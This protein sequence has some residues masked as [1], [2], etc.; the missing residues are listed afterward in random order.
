MK[1]IESMS[2]RSVHGTLLREMAA[3]QDIRLYLKELTEQAVPAAA[4]DDPLPALAGEAAVLHALAEAGERGGGEQAL[5]YVWSASP[6]AERWVEARADGY[7]EGGFTP[8]A[9]EAEEAGAAAAWWGLEVSRLVPPFPCPG[10]ALLVRGLAAR[11]FTRGEDGTHLVCPRHG[12]LVPVQVHVWPLAEGA[13]ALAVLRE[14]VEGRRRWLEAV[15][16]GEALPEEDPLRLAAVVRVYPEDG[17]AV[18]LRTG[19]VGGTVGAAVHPFVL[20]AL[21]APPELAERTEPRQGSE[22]AGVT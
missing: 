4:R 15:G 11:R 5:V 17:A 3:A 21:P 22:G 13:D 10:R 8:P 7:A 9:S 12:N 20:A 6:A 18:D 19:L 2:G 16:R 14:R 1:M